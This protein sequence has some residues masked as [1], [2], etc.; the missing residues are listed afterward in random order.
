[1]YRMHSPLGT[2]AAFNTEGGKSSQAQGASETAQQVA[3]EA[4]AYET[5]L[6]GMYSSFIITDLCTFLFDFDIAYVDRHGIHLV[7]GEC[8]Q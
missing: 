6:D 3:S 5:V 4:S 7:L 2:M 8:C 1:M